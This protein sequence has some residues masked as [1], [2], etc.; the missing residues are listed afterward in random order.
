MEER[1]DVSEAEIAV[2]WQEERLLPSAGE[3]IAQANLT[4]ENVYDRFSLENFPECFN[5]YADLLTGTN[6]GKDA[7]YQ[8]CPVLEVVCRRP[9]QC[10]LQLCRPTSGEVQKQDR[11]PFRSG[12]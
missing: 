6:A 1:I 3:F 7:R 9:D 5:E 8:R 2:H 10:Q 4:D 11:D 12:A